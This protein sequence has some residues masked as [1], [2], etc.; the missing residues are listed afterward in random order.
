MVGAARGSVL[1]PDIDDI[2]T[3]LQEIYRVNKLSEDQIKNANHDIAEMISQGQV[4]HRVIV[5]QLGSVL[6]GAVQMFANS[7]HMSTGEFERLMKA[8]AIGSETI[9]GFVNEMWQA[10]KDTLPK[11]LD[12]YTASLGKLSNAF[13]QAK[14]SIAENGVEPALKTA[15]DSLNTLM[16][17]AQGAQ[18]MKDIGAAL[19]GVITLLAQ[20]PKH[21][22][23]ITAGVAGFL[24]FKLTGF[25]VEAGAA[26]RGFALTLVSAMAPARAAAASM[27]VAQ[28][29]AVGLRAALT[30]AWSSTGL[31]LIIGGIA[32]AVVYLRGGVEDSTQ[33]L[34]DNRV[35][36]DA[37]KDAYD[38][39][40]DKTKAFTAAQSGVTASQVEQNLN[41]QNK[42]LRD[43]M[44][45]LATRAKNLVGNSSLLG[46][47]TP[48]QIDRFQEP[49]RAVQDR[50]GFSRRLQERS[51][52]HRPVFR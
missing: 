14:I 43:Q 27:G 33:A 47:L 45:L 38:K 4:Y 10:G 12:T 3:K 28:A 37:V 26:F 36:V 29:A 20:I 11:A 2:F 19:G 21:L 34:Q 31:G 40:S 23:E 30:A 24:S 5:Q 46:T 1:A 35:V 9:K 25:V 51:R 50:A 17:S 48:E 15:V 8:G 18:M 41:A 7:L 13:F 22:T 6:P 52:R 42:A 16:G 49:D 44:D 32:A 39:A